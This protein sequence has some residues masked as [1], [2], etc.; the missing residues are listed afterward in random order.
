VAA[1]HERSW[2]YDALK[3]HVGEEGARLIAEVIPAEE[4][5]TKE[6]FEM[7]LNAFKAELKSEMRGWMLGFFVPLWIGVYLTLAEIVISIYVGN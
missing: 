6:F 7:K 1:W 3:A 5:V 4:L 2:L